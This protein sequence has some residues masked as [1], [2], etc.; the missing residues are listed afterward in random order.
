MYSYKPSSVCADEILFDVE[1]GR[2][3]NVQFIGGCPGNL[4][5]LANL[6]DGMEIKEAIIRLKGVKCGD[7][8]T[9]CPDQFAKALENIINL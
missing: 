5:G 2:I 1:D 9:S 7:K 6:L 4:I 3:K 8:E